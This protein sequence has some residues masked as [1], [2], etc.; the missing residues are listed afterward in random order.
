LAAAAAAH[1]EVDLPIIDT[2]FTM[3][4][5][6]EGDDVEFFDFNVKSWIRGVVHHVGIRV[7]SCIVRVRGR[8]VRGV[9]PSHM[10]AVY[11]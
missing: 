9:L 8:Y 11:S 7:G 3:H 4:D 6:S 10:R 1:A 5:F 2:S